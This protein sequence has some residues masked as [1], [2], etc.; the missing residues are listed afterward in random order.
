MCVFF[1]LNYFFKSVTKNEI[2][3]LYFIMIYK[4]EFVDLPTLV[5]TFEIT[6][7]FVYWKQ[8]IASIKKSATNIVVDSNSVTTKRFSGRRK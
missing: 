1:I 3:K 5:A 7:V 6:F 8:L 2:N 4:L